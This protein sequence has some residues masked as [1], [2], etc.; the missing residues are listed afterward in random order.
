[1]RWKEVAGG[2]TVIE[3]SDNEFMLPRRVAKLKERAESQNNLV[4]IVSQ[5]QSCAPSGTQSRLF[6]INFWY[7]E[8][9]LNSSA[10]SKGGGAFPLI[11]SICWPRPVEFLNP[12]SIGASQLIFHISHIHFIWSW[13]VMQAEQIIHLPR[14][15]SSWVLS[16][17]CSALPDHDSLR[18]MAS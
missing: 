17:H 2:R 8:Q 10:G 3:T 16:G 7:D 6:S 14:H 13:K 18:L 4:H 1:M 11:P 15:L 9:L 5:W 12:G